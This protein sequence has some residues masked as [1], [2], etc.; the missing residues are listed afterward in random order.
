MLSATPGKTGEIDLSSALRRKDIDEYIRVTGKRL[1]EPVFS[2]KWRSCADYLRYFANDGRAP[3]GLDRQIDSPRLYQLEKLPKALPWETVKEILKAIDKK[4]AIGTQGL[5]HA[6]HGRDV[7]LTGQ[8]GGSDH[9]WTTFVGAKAVCES[10]NA[11]RRRHWSC[12]SPTKS[13]T[14]L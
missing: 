10:I 3:V 7:R 12:L 1:S 2:T 5:R 6:P 11:R 4:S 14:P 8:R 13:R 9:V